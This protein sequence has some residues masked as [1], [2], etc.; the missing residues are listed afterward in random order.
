MEHNKILNVLICILALSCAVVAAVI[1]SLRREIFYLPDKAADDLID[2]LE[3]S[4]ILVDRGIIST[5]KERGYVYV[6]GSGDYNS[7]VATLLSSD[8]I[9]YSFAV[10]EGELIIMSGGARF[11][12]GDGFSFKYYKSGQAEEMPAPLKLS[13]ISSHP[14]EKKAAEI[15]KI[16]AEFMD[17]GSDEFKSSDSLSIVTEVGSVWENSG[18]Y[19]ALC[20]RSIDGVA[21]NDNAVLCVIEGGEV[22][23]AIGTWCFLTLGEAY[24]AQL[25][26]I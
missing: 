3:E 10:P 5:K 1:F 11:E 13:D 22:I 25:C 24:S 12:F 7:T 4:G 2:V 23:E 14:S 26:D 6:C 15:S 19:Y 18:K 9:K 21:I 8:S 17:R 16:V 20:T